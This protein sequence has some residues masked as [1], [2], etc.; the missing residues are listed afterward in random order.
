MPADLDIYRSAKV[1]IDR[2][3]RDA[4]LETA[5]RGDERFEA[6]DLDGQAA[7]PRITAA[8]LDMAEAGRRGASG[9]NH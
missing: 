9:P 8:V 5:I 1:L 4:V 7:W 6:G 2:H 3:Y